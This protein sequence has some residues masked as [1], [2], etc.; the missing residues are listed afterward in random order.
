MF[1][2]V[3][4]AAAEV[5]GPRV[6]VLRLLTRQLARCSATLVY[7]LMVTLTAALYQ[8]RYVRAC[9]AHEAYFHCSSN[10]DVLFAQL[11]QLAMLHTAA[12]T[13]IHKQAHTH[14]HSNA[15]YTLTPSTCPFFYV[16]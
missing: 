15:Q 6:A 13:R 14:T 12:C 3:H 5:Q 10:T 16:T 4:A 9:M 8:R 2:R 11:S 1:C 7:W